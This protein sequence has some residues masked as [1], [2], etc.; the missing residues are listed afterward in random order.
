[1]K[2]RGKNYSPGSGLGLGSLGRVARSS[3]PEE[4]HCETNT[5]PQGL[6]VDVPTTEARQFLGP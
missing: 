4:P 6:E 2:E 3:V 1:M 5:N